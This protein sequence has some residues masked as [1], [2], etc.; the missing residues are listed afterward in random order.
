MTQRRGTRTRTLA[1]V[2][3]VALQLAVCL[4]VVLAPFDGRPH[5]ARVGV[6]APPI[7]AT[8]L[9]QQANALDGRPVRAEA[10]R[11]ARPARAEVRDGRL[12]AALIVDVR[13]NRAVLMVSSAQGSGVVDG[14]TEVA[15][16]LGGRFSADVEVRDIAPA[17]DGSAGRQGLL[18]AVGASVVTGLA[19]AVVLTWRRGPVAD[20]WREAWRRMATGAVVSA[21]VALAVALVASHE[22]GG[23][24]AAW[25]LCAVLAASATCAAT[26]ALEGL[27]G[28]AGIGVATT[29]LV[30][31][32]APLVRVGHP[33]LLPAS[34]GDVVGWLP[35]GAA[36]QA[37][38]Q[39]AFFDATAVVR[40][41]AVLLAWL[42]VALV[43]LAVARRERRRAGVVWDATGRAT[44][45]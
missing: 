15:R 33:L 19:I 9:A 17:P 22:V 25:W 32:A 31:A 12:A 34:W 37:G 16:S 44:G 23:N 4:A 13:T 35:L 2:A 29:V 14:L 7:V 5:G 6:V 28:V 40:P 38:A 27:L 20:T 24:P 8:A 39:I 42:V 45:S 3:V 26:M 30:I 41:L 21:V 11:S 10:L 1:A 18:V 36:L 43:A